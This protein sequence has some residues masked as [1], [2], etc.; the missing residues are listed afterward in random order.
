MIPRMF[1]GIFLAFARTPVK[2]PISMNSSA[3][4]TLPSLR[5][6]PYD[7]T[8]FSQSHSCNVLSS[9]KMAFCTLILSS[10]GISFI[11]INLRLGLCT[12]LR[13]VPYAPAPIFS[14]TMI[15]LSLTLF[16]SSA[17]SSNFLLPLMTGAS[18]VVPGYFRDVFSITYCLPSFA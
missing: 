17:F 11:A 9:I 18:Q 6:E 1:S 15:S 12:A 2:E 3:I 4:L 14:I 10:K 5:K 16:S 7:L 13:T 8:M